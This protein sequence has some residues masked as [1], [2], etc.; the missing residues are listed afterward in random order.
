MAVYGIGAYSADATVAVAS[1][2]VLGVERLDDAADRAGVRDLALPR[3]AN[4]L[5]VDHEAVG[6]F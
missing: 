6:S 2:A 5:R 3:D 1:G 4:L